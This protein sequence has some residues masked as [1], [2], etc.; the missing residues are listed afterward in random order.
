MIP[1]DEESEFV[2]GRGLV[3]TLPALV[4]RD[5]T[6]VVLPSFPPPLEEWRG[7]GMALPAIPC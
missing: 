4:I 7:A 1:G 5:D 3:W 6:G 2:I